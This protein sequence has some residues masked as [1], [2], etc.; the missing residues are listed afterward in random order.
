MPRRQDPRDLSAAAQEYLLALRVGAGAGDGAKVT[1][2][3]VARH[4]GVTTQAASEM[5]RRLVADGLVDHV[6]GGR[7]LRLTTAGR[8][9][10][11]AIFRRHAL[12]EWLL[13]SVV[14]LGWAESDEEAMRLQG[15]ISPRVEAR[16]DEMLGHPETCPHG[17]P[18]DAATAKRRPPG[19]RLSDIE[20][21]THATIYRIT[22]E[23]EE[24][25]G[26]LSYL[27]ARALKPGAPITILARSESLDSLTL[28]GPI[29]RAT[30]GLR[31][32]ASS[33]CSR[34][35]PTR[36]SSIGSRRRPSRPRPSGRHDGHGAPGDRD[37][38]RV[39]IA[40]SPTGPLHIGTARTALYNFLHAR[41]GGG[42]FILRLE[43][44]DVARST[45]EFEK[46]ILDGLHW[47]G[48]TWDEGP[49]VAGE[50]ARGPHAPYRQMERL[51]SYAAAAQRLLAD[52]LAY[53]CFCTP[54]E[55]DADR[56]AQEAAKLP[57]RYVGRCAN[58]TPDER[59]AR[60]AEG[61]R[62][63]LRFRVGEGVVA[64]DDIVRGRVEIDVSNLGGDFVIV[65]ADGTPLYHFTVMVDDAAMGITDVIRGEDHLSNTPKHI[66]LFRALGHEP[67]RFAHL[68][69]I[70][71]A[72]RTKMSKRKSQTAI[73]D[74]IAQGF[75]REALVNYLALLGWSTGTEE[76]IL[77]LDELVERF[78]LGAVHK[79]G[80]VFDRER[81]EWLNGQ[82]IRR[83]D[84]GRP[85]RPAPAVRRGRA[86]RRP[87]RP[88]AV[89]RR[90]AGRCCRS[91]RSACR[92]SA[93]SATW[94]GSCGSTSSRST[95]ATLVPKRWDAATTRDGL[96]GGA[97]DD[98]RRRRGGVRGRRARAAAAGPR[99]GP[100][101][102]GRRP[103]HGHPRRA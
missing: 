69:L 4:L 56:K 10:A 34:A 31:P 63:A 55:L 52:D 12:I 86:G 8:A 40:P 94:S 81:L 72:D 101:L 103:V 65:R 35:T 26:L 23:A 99:R 21:G 27:E 41:H 36:R 66:L 25:A 9:A 30:L 7:E 100:R 17:N 68:P 95:R 53:P 79:G 42:T 32:A 59:Q 91:S 92:P 16:L 19:L 82:W 22:E 90:A 2:A 85:R 29:G 54:E 70:L 80:A 14:G 62:G 20:A 38:D 97:G 43:D 44:T 15:A 11:D 24:D 60:E 78:D 50:P 73:D 61:R 87:D 96:R 102:E 83:L 77:S 37:G 48:L 71:N 47:L 3:G 74:Y 39:R 76:E 1:A 75:I 93:R 18:I 57:P 64:F 67:P 33:G 49:E 58:L 28:D 6:D 89:R 88:D 51:P 13:T 98:R 5:F 46:D 45:V 84:A